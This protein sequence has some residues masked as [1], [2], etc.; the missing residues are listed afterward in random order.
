[1]SVPRLRPD[2][3]RALAL[4]ALM[5]SCVVQA[6]S[7]ETLH[8]HQ[9]YTRAAACLEHAAQGCVGPLQQYLDAAEQTLQPGTPAQTG[10]ELRLR[11]AQRKLYT[12]AEGLRQQA[13]QQLD[14]AAYAEAERLLL[15]AAR[16]DAI[17][18]LRQPA[19]R[20]LTPPPTPPDSVRVVAVLPTAAAEFSP[21]S[22]ETAPAAVA[23][24][25]SSPE[26]TASLP[27]AH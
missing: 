17:L 8:A 15:M 9:S 25:Q 18:G 10:Q 23:S 13:A 4:M 1:M 14:P 6:G 24:A 19:P 20:D 7:L 3:T 16:I 21:A 22:A 12:A 2:P 11:L 27:P 26:E 5:G